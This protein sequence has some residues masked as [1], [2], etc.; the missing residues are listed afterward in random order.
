MTY[1]LAARRLRAARVGDRDRDGAVGR[2]EVG[3]A[4]VHGEGEP[5]D[6]VEVVEKIPYHWFTRFRTVPTTTEVRR[7]IRTTRQDDATA[8]K[9]S[10]GRARSEDPISVARTRRRA[11]GYPAWSSASSSASSPS[12]ASSPG[13]MSSRRWMTWKPKSLRTT[14][15]IPFTSSAKAGLLV[16]RRE[17]AARDHAEVAAPLGARVLR[18]LAGESRRS[19]RRRP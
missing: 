7:P 6:G 9:R 16:G 17:Q 2:D 1:G 5:V 11:P 3:D 10:R 18:L 12:A 14:S 13:G 8:R 19:R 15:L 4:V